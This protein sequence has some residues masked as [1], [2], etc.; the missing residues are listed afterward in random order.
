MLQKY[1]GVKF[2][3]KDIP[4]IFAI[5]LSSFVYSLGMN[6]F[7]KA[8]N[9]FPAGYA[10]ISRLLS[11]VFQETFHLA[12]SFSVI[13]WVLNVVTTLVI[14]KRIGHKFVL[15]SVLWFTLTSIF[16]GILPHLVVTRDALLISIF[17][18]AV[19]GIAL[20]IALRSN[21]SSGGMDFIAIDLS[22]RLNRPT[23]NYIFAINAVVLILAGARYGWD[24]SLYSIIFQY[25]SKEIVNR[26]H[27]RYK[28]SRI[29]VVTDQPEDVSQA[30]FAHV[31]HGITKLDCEGEYSHK[32]HT[33]LMLSVNTY[34]INEI[35]T[36]IKDVDPKCFISVSNVERVIGNYYQ[37]PLE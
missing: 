29:H 11:M 23:W 13:Y 17:G 26:M 28:I 35:I 18:G 31:R 5:I 36:I 14:W 6:A 33:M 22:T 34:Q 8:G 10:G 15:F 9:L 30:V 32:K 37:K 19:N 20:G 2:T 7:V 16:T 4:Y 12:I 24:Q 21:G 25:I 1:I 27:Q 3:K